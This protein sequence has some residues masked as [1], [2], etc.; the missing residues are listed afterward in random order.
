MAYSAFTLEVF[1]SITRA[2]N[3]TTTG[4]KGLVGFVHPSERTLMFVVLPSEWN[5]M[6]VVKMMTKNR[7]NTHKPYAAEAL[8]ASWR[9]HTW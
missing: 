6:F 3:T 4:N 2:G 9:S 8:A 7:R 5:G 1:H